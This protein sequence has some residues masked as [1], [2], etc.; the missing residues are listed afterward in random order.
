MDLKQV[1]GCLQSARQ[2][3]LHAEEAFGKKK[4]IRGELDLLLAQAELRRVREVSRSC[5]WRYRFSFLCQ[6]AAFLLAVVMVTAGVGGAYWLM[7]QSQ[8]PIA[9]PQAVVYHTASGE[10]PKIESKVPEKPVQN[11]VTEPAYMV[12]P[13]VN[14]SPPAHQVVP[15]ENHGTAATAAVQDKLQEHASQDKMVSSDEMQKLVRA[16]GKSLRGQ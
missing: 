15:R 12:Q 13:N 9:M 7:K 8:Q 6:M 1:G 2:W 16:A 5:H 10:E 14:A 3:I 4:D 11:T